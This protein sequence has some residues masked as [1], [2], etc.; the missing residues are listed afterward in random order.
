M[1]YP[2]EDYL[3][4]RGRAIDCLSFDMP[5]DPTNQDR[6]MVDKA[7]AWAMLA[8]AEAIRESAFNGSTNVA[9]RSDLS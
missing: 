2:G 6:A 5:Q 4:Y 9:T 1:S 3:E 7:Q 8:L